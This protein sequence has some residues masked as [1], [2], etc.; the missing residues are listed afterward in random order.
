M[1]Y[2]EIPSTFYTENRK[3]LLPLLK[4]KSLALFFSNSQ[5]PRTGDQYFPFRQ[6]ANLFY[7][8]GIDQPNAILALCPHHPKADFREILFVEQITPEKAIWNGG[9]HSVQDLRTISG[10]QTILWISDFEYILRDLACYS[11]HIYLD[12]QENI[13][14]ASE[15][16]GQGFIY[17]EKIKSDYPLHPYHR[18]FPLLADMRLIKSLY[19]IEQ[20]KEACRI[21]EKAFGRIPHFLKPHVWEYE[22]E[23]EIMHEFTKHGACCAFDTIVASGKNACT[24]HYATNDSICEDGDLLLLDFGA[25]YANY[26]SDLSRT[27]P[28]NG[29]FSLRQRQVYDACVRVYEYAKT[30]FIPGMSISKVY[31]K[32][33]M[34]MQMELI[35]LGLFSNTDLE[36]QSSEYELMKKYFPHNISHFV[37][38]DV[39]DVGNTDVL[40]EEG[41]ILSCEPGIYIP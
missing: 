34:T 2:K 9:G 31:K 19:E 35:D 41:M 37:G 23:A 21:T 3:R 15:I 8:S 25:E 10:I 28:V 5:M 13:K 1:K 22:V 29:R 16:K 18:L 39:H 36:K 30:L 6:N 17:A 11:Y 27:I 24:L 40:F 7:M 33:C 38:L 26:A 4:D 20:I 32:V 12:I 14:F